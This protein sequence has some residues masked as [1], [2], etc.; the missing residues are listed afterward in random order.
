[1]RD[2]HWFTQLK[3][4]TCTGIAKERYS[5]GGKEKKKRSVNT[6]MS[7]RIVDTLPP[8]YFLW[9]AV[10]VIPR[11]PLTCHSTL[12]QTLTSL[13][14]HN[15]IFPCILLRQPYL[16]ACSPC[17]I[18]RVY[19][20]GSTPPQ[21]HFARTRVQNCSVLSTQPSPNLTYESWT[22]EG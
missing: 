8:V 17:Q 1:M 21:L 9:P 4:S 22:F 12:A 2:A 7:M 14:S 5:T 18:M 3:Y 16:L 6:S 10:A 11:G 13:V 19:R 15:S 20:T